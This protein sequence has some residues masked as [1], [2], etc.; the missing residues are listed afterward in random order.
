[1]NFMITVVG[2]EEQLLGMVVD[3]ERE[4]LGVAKAKIIKDNNDFNIKLKQ[5]EEIL[6]QLTLL[7]G[8]AETQTKK[9][10]FYPSQM[11]RL[12]C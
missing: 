1:M 3:K 2:L 9:P 8:V 12:T 4:D 5:L 10:S 7:R 6:K 11:R